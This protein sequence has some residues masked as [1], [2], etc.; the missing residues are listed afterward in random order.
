MGINTASLIGR[1]LCHL[2]SLLAS[3]CITSTRWLCP[4]LAF[5]Y[6]QTYPLTISSLSH[7][8]WSLDSA[9]RTR[10]CFPCCPRNYRTP[11]H[12]EHELD[13]RER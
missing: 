6:D 7:V 9:L 2:V 3:L 1:G 11:L 4:F 8:D 10:E 13:R 5:L 12:V